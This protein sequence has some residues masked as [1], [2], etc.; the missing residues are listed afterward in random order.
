MG[1]FDFLSKA[2]EN[3][4]RQVARKIDSMERSGQV[5]SERANAARERLSRQSEASERVFDKLSSAT[6]KVSSSVSSLSTSYDESDGKTVDSWDTEWQSIG[7]LKTADL[8]PYNKSVGLYKLVVNGEIKYIGRAIELN[9]GGFRKRLSDYRRDSDSARKHQ[10]GQTIHQNLDKIEAYILVV[11]SDE[12]A[13]QIT[14][15]LEPMFIKKYSPEWNR[16]F[17]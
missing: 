10:S 13:V 17:K 15:S 5:S 4:E 16:N 3:Y 11:G 12:T 7:M 1:L 2:A 6:E 9:N 14:K 8:T